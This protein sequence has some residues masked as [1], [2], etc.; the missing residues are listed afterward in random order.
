MKLPDA[1]DV[2]TRLPNA[3]RG[4][5]SYPTSNPAANALQGFGNTLAS[6]GFNAAAKAEDEN[7]KV[8]DFGGKSRFFEFQNNVDASFEAAKLKAAP[9]ATGFVDAFGKDFEPA[10]QQFLKSIPEELRPEYETRLV[11]YAGRV[12][13]KAAEFGTLEGIR[14]EKEQIGKGQERLINEQMQ[15]PADY[16]RVQEEGRAHIRAATKLPP[17]ERDI[18]EQQWDAKSKDALYVAG[19]REV[20]AD[21]SIVSRTPRP[22]P[23]DVQ[24][25]ANAARDHFVALGYTPAQAAGIVGNLV[26]ESGVVSDGPTGDSG[27]AHGMA[28]WRGARFTKLQRFAASRGKDWRDWTTQLDFVDV[29]LKDD[30]PQAYAKLKSA[31]TVDEATAAFIGFERPSGWSPENPRG[32]HGWSNRL[33]A[34]QRTAGEPVTATSERPE[35]F[36]DLPPDRQYALEQQAERRFAQMDVE[37]AA[38]R[39]VEYNQERDG[40][41]LGI[42]TGTVTSDRDILLNPVLDD[43]DKATLLRSFRSKTD[44]NA[45]VSSFL[46]ELTSGDGLTV[47]PFNSEQTAVAD[48]AFKKWAGAV[49]EE[50]RPAA[51]AAFISETGYIPKPVVAEIQMGA[52]A[53]DAP[54]LAAAMA[55]ADQ[56]ERLAPTS[57]AKGEGMAAVE[58]KLT[59]YRHFTN[60]RGMS[61]EQAA[62]KML[63][64]EKP[65]NKA[66]REILKP[67]AEKMRKDMT[68]AEVTS[69]FDGWTT[70]EPGAGLLAPQQNVLLQEYQELAEQRLYETG[71]EATAKAMALSDLKKVWNI[72]SVSGTPQLMRYPPELHYPTIAGGHEYLHDDALKTAE[73]FVKDAFPGRTVTGVAIDIDEQRTRRDISAGI[74]PRYRLFYTYQENGQTL[75]DEV[76]SDAGPW[77]MREQDITELVKRDAMSRKERGDAIRSGEAAAGQIER[78]GEIDATR[79]IEETTGP[80][81]MKAKAAEA[82]RE[83]ARQD[84]EEARKRSRIKVEPPISPID[85]EPAADIPLDTSFGSAM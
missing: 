21:P 83:K 15:S 19:Q 43:G 16:K 45:E 59:M 75:T 71:D 46:G 80:D 28:Q 85:D 73:Q 40:L 52:S 44:E 79:A 22:V 63:E 78:Q 70:T 51:T 29:E 7:L 11:D 69:A 53:T 60:S 36:N 12:R 64:M 4:Q 76:I 13:A 74:P 72:S 34:A 33:A 50:N 26:Q 47:N 9:G 84:A 37:T 81:W 58:D 61:S 57:F 56:I 39:K 62:S 55:T 38:T 41:A 77:G 10:A 82:V 68:V 49:P 65:E 24:S 18:A 66:S 1:T 20:E 8:Q 67:R 30:E 42:E 48:K 6:V 54:S 35:W 32:G 3:V 5:P 27:S 14:Y 31:G 25:R 2:G 17:I 23:A